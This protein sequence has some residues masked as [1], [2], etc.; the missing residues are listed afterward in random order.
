MKT[1]TPGDGTPVPG[2]PWGC[3]RVDQTPFGADRSQKNMFFALKISNFRFPKVTENPAGRS[4]PRVWDS[5]VAVS[6]ARIL[7]IATRRCV[8]IPSLSS[9][10]LWRQ[11]YLHFPAGLF[12]PFWTSQD[13]FRSTKRAPTVSA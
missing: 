7:Q 6:S 8:H 12:W 3:S 10:S 5:E 4:S 13:T 1:E 9:S 11:S 2:R